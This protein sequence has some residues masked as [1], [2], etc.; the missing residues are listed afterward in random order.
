MNDVGFNSNLPNGSVACT[1]TK[2][3]TVNTIHRYVSV[4]A[5]GNII[6]SVYTL[7]GTTATSPSTNCKTAGT[8]AVSGWNDLP[9]TSEAGCQFNNGDVIYAICNTDT[10]ALLY[11]WTSPGNNVIIDEVDY[12]VTYPGL[13]NPFTAAVAQSGTYFSYLTVRAR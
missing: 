13:L 9:V 2:N 8:A 11:G 6:C 10:D 1:A 7:S 12:P 4:P 3:I 5:S